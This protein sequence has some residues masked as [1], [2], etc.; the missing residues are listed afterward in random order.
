MALILRT[1]RFRRPHWC[2]HSIVTVH[3][4]NNDGAFAL[5]LPLCLPVSTAY[6][7][8]QYL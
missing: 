3:I 6:H 5:S 1:G 8:I 2:A 7:P 4:G